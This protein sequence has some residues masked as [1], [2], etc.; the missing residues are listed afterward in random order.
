MRTVDEHYEGLDKKMLVVCIGCHFQKRFV[1]VLDE[2][3]LDLLA[4]RCLD[5]EG[6]TSSIRKTK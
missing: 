6:S 2:L 1:E 4:V 3:C 5:M